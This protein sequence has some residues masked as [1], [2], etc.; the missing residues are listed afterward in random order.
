MTTLTM[1]DERRL[2]IIQRVYRS[3]L[4]VVQAA[5]VMG[6]SE[7]QC[8]RVKARVGKAGAKGV[9]HGN[10]GRR[11]KRKT[12]E[13][14]VRRV[15]ALARGKY[16]GFNDH[17]LTEKLKEQEQIELSREKVRRILRAE[18]IASPRKRRGIK[19]RSRR[20]RRA[21]EG[22]MLQVDGSP[23]DWLQGRGPRMCLIGA[24][25]DATNKVMGALFV[26][27]ESSWGYFHL[28]SKIFK[29]HG[30]SQSIYTD[31]HSVFWTDREPTIDEQMINRKPTTEVGRGLE[32]LG[33][34]LI[35]AHSPQAKGRIERLWNTF[36]D[37][38]VSE[39]RLAK[40]KTMEQAT[41]V[42]DRY[43]PVHNRKFS[44]PA[45][46][47]SAWR[48]VSS[49]QIER[50]LCFK[51]QRTVAKDN[52]V[53]FEGTVLQIPKTSPFRSHANKRI[54]VHVLL[55]G[56]VE[57]FYKSEKIA[58]FDSKTTH[59]IGLYRTNTKKEGFRY[60]PLSSLTTQPDVSP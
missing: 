2:D 41:V 1:Q 15:V 14:V 33:V 43:L 35:L 16:Q 8:Y 53:T 58:T 45:T 28:F 3:E 32:E 23:H 37:R 46:A 51:Q 22:M 36:Q 40:A 38:L 13:K 56:A 18:G 57:F 5:L 48:K 21:S 54:D 19:H 4:T 24:I 31:C 44:M 25:D 12:K 11:C 9:V 7:R 29:E 34:T 42:L 17:H 49:L 10:R 27:A 26:Q 50:A 55:D 52:T 20:E 39:L 6:V 30:V 60:G 47:E 59:T